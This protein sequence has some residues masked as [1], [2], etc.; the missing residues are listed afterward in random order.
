MK[1]RHYICTAPEGVDI[2]SA[3]FCE[4]VTIYTLFI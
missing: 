3:V 1:N 4:G 2:Y